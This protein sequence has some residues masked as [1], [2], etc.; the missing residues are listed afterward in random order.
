MPYKLYGRVVD[1]SSRRAM[2][3][4][5]VTITNHADNTALTTYTDAGGEFHFDVPPGNYNIA[6]ETESLSTESE[7]VVVDSVRNTV[8][9]LHLEPK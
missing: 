8:L 1:A 6:A 5:K 3:A 9:V 4:A 2:K 7:A